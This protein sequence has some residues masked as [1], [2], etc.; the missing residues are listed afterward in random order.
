MERE[1]KVLMQTTLFIVIFSTAGCGIQSSWMRE[2]FE[3]KVMR[4]ESDEVTYSLFLIGDAGDPMNESEPALNVLQMMASEVRDRAMIIFL[5][6]NIY[7][8]GLPTDGEERPSAQRKLDV[9]LE[10]V[11]RSG[12]P[13][14]FIPGNHDWEKSGPDGWNRI[15][16]QQRYIDEVGKG[17]ISFQPKDGCP[18]PI[19]VDLTADLQLV[20]LD[21]EWWLRTEDKP[22]NP[23]S[24]CAQGTTEEFLAALRN[25]LTDRTKR[26]IVVAHHP[27]KTC[28]PHGGFFSWKSHLFPLT[29]IHPAL[30]IPLPAVGSLY[31]LARNLG[32][33]RQD[34]SHPSYRA[35]IDSL[36][37]VFENDP[38]VLFAAGHEHTLQVFRAKS[39]LH[40]VVSGNGILGHN[41]ELTTDDTM[42]F[43]SPLSG[44]MKVD[45]TRS[46]KV[47]LG[48][49]IVEDVPE[50]TEVFSL[51]LR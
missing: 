11:R 33:T 15:C 8:D 18:G 26:H 41:S 19:A 27:L 16:A 34:M 36:N 6:D 5:G 37:Q 4:S 20:I 17:V 44:L 3:A 7:P 39:G 25:L 1:M 32:I 9:Q 14:I 12:A 49:W 45:F 48:V 10:A 2:P 42:L 43:G 22:R 13:G 29:N 51:W 30:W 35:L 38:P 47:R 21:T 23:G 50:A 24:A 40:S 46:G 28:G 31:P